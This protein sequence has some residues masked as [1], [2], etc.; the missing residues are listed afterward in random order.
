ML[1]NNKRYIIEQLSQCREQ[2]QNLRDEDL[3]S[4]IMLLHVGA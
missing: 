2:I 4:L 3:S 1:R